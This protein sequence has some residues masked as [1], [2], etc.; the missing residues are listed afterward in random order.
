M[1]VVVPIALAVLGAA[2]AAQ[3]QK[4]GAMASQSA[5]N[6]GSADA[7]R[8]A[9]S[10][11]AGALGG[12]AAQ[13]AAPQARTTPGQF[14]ASPTG[15]AGAGGEARM[16]GL[17]ASGGGYGKSPS[18]SDAPAPGAG[19]RNEFAAPREAAGANGLPNPSAENPALAGQSFNSMMG[20]KAE[21]GIDAV[22]QDFQR[23]NMINQAGP[24]TAP[25]AS[26]GGFNAA[27]AAGYAEQGAKLGM[28]MAPRPP[29]PV[30]IPNLGPTPKGIAG[31]FMSAMG[32]RRPIGRF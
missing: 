9:M 12:T 15:M 8:K 10:D 31:D 1:P 16:E 5:A 13:A 29:S 21:P 27:A 30:G 28:A 2:Q 6:Q 7:N 4:A 17:I 3:Q 14:A 18:I 20:P 25:N 23:Q 24:G 32:Q 11:A 22:T 19:L 26:G